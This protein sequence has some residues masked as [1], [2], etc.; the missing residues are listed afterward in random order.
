MKKQRVMI[1]EGPDGTG[2]SS[3]AK[4][5]SEHFSIPYFKFNAEHH[6]WRQKSFKTALEFD[7]PMMLQYLQQTRND[8]IWDRAWPSEWVYS[9]VFNR[10][11]NGKLLSELDKAYSEMGIWIIIPMR[12]SY[13]NV[14]PDEIIPKDKII[15]IHGMY[16]SFCSWSQCATMRIYVD[17]F[18]NDIKKQMSAVLPVLQF[19]ANWRQSV[20][21]RG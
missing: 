10:E 14:R 6:Y 20:I 3:I 13:E 18:D 19:P 1:F 11:T 5:M 16:E 21:V 8:L 12:D 2:K 7:Q 9:Q 17:S 4:F 15:Q